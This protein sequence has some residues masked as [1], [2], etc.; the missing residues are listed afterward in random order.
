MT[1]APG[2]TPISYLNCPR[3]RLTIR[4]D[5]DETRECPRCVGRLGTPVPMF[6]TRL[7]YYRRLELGLRRPGSR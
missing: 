3:C 7:P 2:T 1:P 5:R 4:T 6:L